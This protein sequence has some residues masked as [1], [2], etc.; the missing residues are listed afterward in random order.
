EECRKGS[1]CLI[2]SDVRMPGIS[3]TE[4]LGMIHELDPDIPVILMT[5]FAEIETAIDAVRKGA[6]DFIM[7]PFKPE[8]LKHAIEKGIRFRNLLETEK[9]YLLMMEDKLRESEENL[10]AAAMIQ[11]NFLPT[12]PPQGTPF[13]FAWQF[14]PCEKV[15]GDLFNLFWLNEQHLGIYLLDVG[16]HGVPAAM[17]T[18]S[19]AQTLEHCRGWF[20]KR[21]GN[22]RPL[23]SPFTP[24]DVLATLNEKYPVERFGQLLTICYLILDMKSGTILYSN[25]ALPLPFIIR[26][27]GRVERLSKGGIIIGADE[28]ATYENGNVIM[29]SGDRLFIYTD[30]ITEYGNTNGKAYGEERLVTELKRSQ[31]EALQTACAAAIRHLLEFGDNRL[32][33]DDITLLGVEFKP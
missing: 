24:A 7:K 9:R 15:G 5:A 10:R 12:S 33:E 8:L 20:C 6:F 27:D 4:L 1:I 31:G 11:Q 3:G 30:G 25:A 19:V 28:N 13:N 16:G 29:Q 14:H 18:T 17:V 26:S 32:S 22:E 23:H 2:V 21:A